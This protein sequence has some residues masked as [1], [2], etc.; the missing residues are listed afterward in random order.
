MLIAF[1]V[2]MI[3]KDLFAGNT[4]A[5]SVNGRIKVRHVRMAPT[6]SIML[7]R[8]TKNTIFAFHHCMVMAMEDYAVVNFFTY[9]FT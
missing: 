1:V 2:L 3:S 5:L 4:R 6:Y 9:S 7:V 8:I